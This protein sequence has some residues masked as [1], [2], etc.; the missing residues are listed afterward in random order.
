MLLDEKIFA[1]EELSKKIEFVTQQSSERRDEEIRYKNMNR[2]LIIFDL[3]DVEMMLA[4]GKM[5]QPYGFNENFEN[6][7][8][9]SKVSAFRIWAEKKIAKRAEDFLRVLYLKHPEKFS[10]VEYE[11]SKSKKMKL[12]KAS[13]ILSELT[14]QKSISLKDDRDDHLAQLNEFKDRFTG[15]HQRLVLQENVMKDLT[16]DDREP[17]QTLLE[18]Q[19][20]QAK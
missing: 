10:K 7:M 12:L 20:G 17:E 18:M 1:S 3:G 15:E 4:L 2:K 19:P 9:Y 5:L 6:K 13:Y 16:H 14:S 8:L 11:N